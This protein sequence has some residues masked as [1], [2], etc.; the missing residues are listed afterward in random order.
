[1]PNTTPTTAQPAAYSVASVAASVTASSV[2]GYSD[3]AGGYYDGYNL[4]FAKIELNK[5]HDSGQGRR[6]HLNNGV[7]VC[8]VIYLHDE[9]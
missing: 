6:I 4:Q 9:S 8:Y 1:M 2:R 7:G 3:G 5:S